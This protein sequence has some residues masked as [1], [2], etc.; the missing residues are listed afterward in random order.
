MFP[1]PSLQRRVTALEGDEAEAAEEGAA[2][3]GIAEMAE[4]RLL[5][6]T[7]IIMPIIR[8]SKI[9]ARQVP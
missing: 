8:E 5:P 3:E 7:F 2:V 1:R 6:Y 9:H 4:A